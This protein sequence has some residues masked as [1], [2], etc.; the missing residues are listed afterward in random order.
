M[1]SSGGFRNFST[2]CVP[3]DPPFSRRSTTHNREVGCFESTWSIPALHDA[4]PSGLITV[5]PTWTSVGYSAP[6]S[7]ELAP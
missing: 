1:V 5:P 4:S 6:V 7:S 2:A 3:A